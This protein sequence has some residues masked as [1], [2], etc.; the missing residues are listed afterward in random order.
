MLC[1]IIYTLLPED[2]PDQDYYYQN[3]LTIMKRSKITE[4]GTEL[5]RY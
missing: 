5:R 1:A 3:K 2:A 4:I